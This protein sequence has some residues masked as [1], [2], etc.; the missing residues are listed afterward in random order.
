VTN[1]YCPRAPWRTVAH[2]AAVVLVVKAYSLL[3]LLLMFER[4]SF[5]DDYALFVHR[6]VGE[7][8]S[9]RLAEI[10]RDF[11]ERLA[12]YDG[13]FYLD[14]AYRGYR[15][16]QPRELS[17]PPVP[18]GNYAFFPLLPALTRVCSALPWRETLTL[19]VLNTLFS[20]AA[21][22]WLWFLARRLGVPAWSA[23]FVALSFPTA[24]YQ[25]ALYTEALVLFLSLGYFWFAERGATGRAAA[26]GALAGLCRPQGIL[27]ALLVLPRWCSALAAR[28]RTVFVCT[29]VGAAPAFGVAVFAAI[30]AVTIGDPL[31]FVK[32]QSLWGRGFSPSSIGDALATLLHYEGPPV[33]PLALVFGVGLLPFLWRTLPRSVALYGTGA[34]LLPLATGSLLSFGRFVSVSWPHFLCLAKLLERWPIA[35]YALLATF[36]ALQV[37]VAKGL[38]GWYFVG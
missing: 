25:S 31:G 36:I 5:C 20:G 28:D 11:F 12:P 23:A 3:L 14:I 38:V 8:R 26:L 29:I 16:F 21:I 7:P 24:V 33:D 18:D 32:I 15:R 22:T 9:L 13:Q 2:V 35:R 34:V 30:L 6:E 19:V 1:Q 17:G 10:R 27:V 4:G 37:L